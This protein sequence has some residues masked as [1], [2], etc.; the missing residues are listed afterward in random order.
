MGMEPN[1]PQSLYVSRGGFLVCV[2]L[3][4]LAAVIG[5]TLIAHETFASSA[6]YDE[7][8]YIRIATYWWRTG[9]QSAITRMGSPLLFWKLQQAPMLWLLDHAGH[10]NWVNNPIGYQK[11]LLL[12][13]RL[14]SG[15]IWIVAFV[16]TVLWSRYSHGPYAMALAAWLFTL[17]PN[18]LA[19]GSLITM[20]LPL[21]ATATTMFYLFWRFLERNRTRW[22]W[23]SAAVSGLAFSCKFTTI[24][25]APILATI[26][27]IMRLWKRERTV[28]ALT[29]QVAMQMAGFLFVMLLVNFTV[30]GFARLPLSTSHGHHSTIER[31]FGTVGCNLVA[32]LYETPLP[33]DWVGF[34]TQTHHQASGGPSYLLG[35][36]RM[37][38]W[39]TYYPIAVAVKVPIAFWILATLRIGLCR[40]RISEPPL[41]VNSLLP[42][43]FL[44][45]LTI[46]AIGSSRNYG[47]RYLLPL[48][49]LAIV[50]VSALGDHLR[51][52]PRRLAILIRTT[53]I[54]SLAG[55]AITVAKIHPYEL[56]YFNSIVG[57]PLGG[58]YILADSNLDWSQGLESLA[59]L[60]QGRPELTNLTLYYFGD[61]DPAYY[62]VSGA[63]RT[64]NAVTAISDLP[65]LDSIRTPFLAVSASLQ[66]GPW[67]PPRFF[68]SLE[69]VHPIL[70]TDDTT[71]TIYRT[72]DIE[73]LLE[74]KASGL[75]PKV[76]P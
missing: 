57:G 42:V 66:W 34:A 28:I 13:A 64:I 17:S 1:N 38:G 27:W 51:I 60:Q 9:D 7:L 23:A 14:A 75:S 68:K 46:T 61:T 67:G 16:V 26:W 73:H 76:S 25:V 10:P 58:R 3:T 48:A 70:L 37:K 44:L 11:Q 74:A 8:T 56:T 53:V 49:P 22:F 69:S 20:E 15:W 2:C 63:S 5:L 40:C 71:I 32:Q 30:T 21:V 33:Q 35:E 54:I 39:S 62:D 29:H 72:A 47:V 52:R 36:R 50:W 45:Y 12:M 24:L 41:N 31:W 43:V 59:R 4:I 65:S 6:T 18:L 55:Y 19:H